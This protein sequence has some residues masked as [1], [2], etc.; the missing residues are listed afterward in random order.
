S[1]ER[2]DAQV[3]GLHIESFAWDGAA[4][5]FDLALDTWETPDGL[6]AALTYATDLFEAR[7]VERMARH[8]QNLLRAMLVAPAARIDTL[9]ML[10]AD[11]RR[12]ML[13]TWNA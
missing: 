4:A 12:Q 2:Q 3:D 5:Q 7:T 10:E 11:E 6:G 13:E 1:G 8:W 9:P